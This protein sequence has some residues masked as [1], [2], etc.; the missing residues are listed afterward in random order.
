MTGGEVVRWFTRVG[1]WLPLQS[2]VGGGLT[3]GSK[4]SLSLGWLGYFPLTRWFGG[5]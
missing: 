3:S 4:P 5:V 2:A 1:S